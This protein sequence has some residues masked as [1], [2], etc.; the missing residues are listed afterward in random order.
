MKLEEIINRLR[1]ALQMSVAIMGGGGNGSPGPLDQ[2]FLQSSKIYV[3][4]KILIQP[5]HEEEFLKLMI[6]MKYLN[7]HL[8]STPYNL[9]L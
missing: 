7:I 6:N 8:L 9:Y 3:S 5:F 2:L 4:Y 1:V